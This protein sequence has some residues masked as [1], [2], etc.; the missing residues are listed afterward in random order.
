MCVPRS[1]QQDDSDITAGL[2]GGKGKG[3]TSGQSRQGQDTSDGDGTFATDAVKGLEADILSIEEQVS[4]FQSVHRAMHTGAL[5]LGPC[6]ARSEWYP[7]AYVIDLIGWGE[8]EHPFFCCS[9][10]LHDVCTEQVKWLCRILL[11]EDS[12]QEGMKPRMP[13]AAD[14]LTAMVHQVQQQD[15]R[16]STGGPPQPPTAVAAVEMEGDGHHPE[17]RRIVDPLDAA[18]SDIMDDEDE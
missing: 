17:R 11:P 4:G 14:A 10:D 13:T 12:Q 1:I 3:S 16:L 9:S 18:L 15:D 7:A 8:E 2:D 6:P 5:V